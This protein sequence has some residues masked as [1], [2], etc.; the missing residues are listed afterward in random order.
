[1]SHSA[2]LAAVRAELRDQGLAGV[3][4]P[5]ADE[6][7]GEYVPES[8]ERLAWLTGFTGSAGIAAVLADEAAVW[9]DGRYVLQLA[10]ETDATLWQ[11]LHIQETPPP[12]WLAP[13]IGAGELGYDPWLMSEDQLKPYREANLRLRA[14]T[15]NP[16]DAAWTDR[17]PAPLAP[18]LPHRLENAG[19]P[20]EAKRAAVAATLRARNEDAAV[21]SDPASLAWL[22]NIRGQDVPFTP[23]ALGFA[24]IHA[25]DQVD[26]F[27]APEK[28]PD[29]TRAWLGNGVACAPREALAPALAALRGRR[30][31]VDP[32]NS[33]AWFAERLREAGAEVVAGAD[34]CLLPKARK[35]AVEQAGARSAH[36]EDA[37][38]ITRFLH[39]LS[40]AA[41]QTDELDAAARLLAF[42]QE[43]G[44][45]RGASFST[46]MGAGPNGAII[47]YHAT[48]ETN[49]R[50]QPNETVLIDSG[51][52]YPAG[53]TDIT[54]TVW[55]GPDAPSSQLRDRFTRVLKGH[56]AIATLVFPENTP[57]VRIDAFARAALWRVGLDY[58]HGTGHG[59]GSFLSVHEGPASISPYLRPAGITAG[60]LLSN[61][62][63]FYLPGEYGIRIENLVLA[64]PAEISGAKPFLRFETLSLAPIDRALIEPALLTPDEHAWLDAYHARVV[65]EVSPLLPEPTAAWL[66]QA[67]A[68]LAA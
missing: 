10:A 15:R 59:V 61:E 36:L 23:F 30:V 40:G 45:N 58:D 49:R 34:P 56:I 66:R 4:V 19:E 9:S 60:M 46:I 53:T 22:L 41:G 31:R 29:E 39:W 8:A 3:L 63:G 28:L 18:A 16:V 47:H 37:V 20:S 68:P 12:E 7:L 26:L 57:G 52:Q 24:L 51:G 38:A 35:N 1:M 11:R 13:R 54:R 55:L 62:P 43:G 21:I 44:N 48:T 67:C 65:A 33:A 42:R 27:M 14:V 5:R 25:S 2:R 50:I 64:Q 17:P 6:H 32:V